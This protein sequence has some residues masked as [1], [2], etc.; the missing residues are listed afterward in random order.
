MSHAACAPAQV[1]DVSGPA[2]RSHSLRLRVSLV[3]TAL[4]AALVLAGAALWVRDARLAIAE[5][6]TAAHRVAAQ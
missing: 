4:A 5:E 1:A 3:L 6:I 2:A